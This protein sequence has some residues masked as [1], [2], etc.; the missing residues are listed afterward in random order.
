MGYDV[1]DGGSTASVGVLIDGRSLVY[2]AVGD[3]AGILA[4]PAVPDS[5]VSPNEP[6]KQPCRVV[7]DHEALFDGPEHQIDVFCKDARG[8]WKLSAE[9]ARRADEMGCVPKTARG[10]RSIKIV[11]PD[12]T[13]FS[14][15]ELNVTR[16]LGDFIHQPYGVTWRPDVV[17]KQLEVEIGK[18]PH[19]VLCVASDGVWDVWPSLEQCMGELLG[20]M[21]PFARKRLIGE[22]F[23]TTRLKGQDLF[24]DTADN[25]TGVVVC[26][27]KRAK[28]AVAHATVVTKG[29]SAA[30][31][32]TA[33]VVPAKGKIITAR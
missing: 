26:L 31:G 13:N 10:D 9:N 18:A 14:Q 4:V 20:A 7:Y 25:L 19:A 28:P 32:D 1:V 24:S 2:A 12:D 30:H 29:K 15:M 3:S 11:T 17:C 16:A 21:R 33:P 6:R 23:E 8:G 22:F 5:G 27:S